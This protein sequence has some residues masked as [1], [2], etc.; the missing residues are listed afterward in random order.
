MGLMSRMEDGM[1]NVFEG[2]AQAVFKASL[3]PVQITK[4]AVKEMNRN[5]L[6]G[7]GRQY[8][9]TLYNV[10]VSE[11]DDQKLGG[12]YP[13]LA[14]EIETV[15]VGKAQ[16]HGLEMDGAPLVRFIVDDT[17][18]KGKFDIIAESVAAPIVKKLRQE[19]MLRYGMIPERTQHERRAARSAADP[20]EPQGAAF[21]DEFVPV[22]GNAGAAGFGG[23]GVGV[24]P[25]INDADDADV[26]GAFTGN[27][28]DLYEQDYYEQ[29]AVPAG[30]ASVPQRDIPAA[31]LIDIST[32]DTYLVKGH[33]VLLGREDD[34]DVRILDANV[35][36][37]HA[38]FIFENGRWNLEDLGSTNGTSVN[39]RRISRTVLADGDILVV[40]V[41]KLKFQER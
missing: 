30:R 6:V 12:Y 31:A 22:N 11:T 18:K 15:L 3:N 13:T 35:S 1:E 4:R 39:H 26:P 7:S 28:P 8:A 14:R 16:E 5:K 41:T 38:A 23:A 20:F 37:H 40:G 29:P 25:V 27:A 10:L 17:L 21:N 32:G 36:R 34:C 9:P 19:E 24:L 33:E 2:G